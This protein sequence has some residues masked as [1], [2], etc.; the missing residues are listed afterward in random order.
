[1][2]RDRYEQCPR[3][4]IDLVSAGSVRMCTQCSGH[5]VA[6]DVLREMA[7]A[8]LIPARPVEIELVSDRHPRLP[9]PACE[10]L[11]E[12]WRMHDVPIDRC[13]GH[14]LW[15]DRE[16]LEAVLFATAG[17]VA[18][19]APTEVEIELDS[20]SELLKSNPG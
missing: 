8:M 13:P 7:E 18:D 19:R 16:E 5:W 12:T 15:F 4:R 14:G 3:C 6:G 10:Q 11:M 9:C 20:L 17:R 2:Y 1:M